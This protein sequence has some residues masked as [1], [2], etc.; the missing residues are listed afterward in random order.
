MIYISRESNVECQYVE[1]YA[2]KEAEKLLNNIAYRKRVEE[3]RKITDIEE[4]REKKKGFPYRMAHGYP[5]NPNY[6]RVGKNDDVADN[7]RLL[8]D[9]DHQDAEEISKMFESEGFDRLG[10]LRIERSIGGNG[11]HI[12][13][14]RMKGLTR[15]Q[16]I[17]FYEN[18]FQLHIDHSCKDVR[19][20][21]FLV[22]QSDVLYT[23]DEFYETVSA[24]IEN[25][26]PEDMNIDCAFYKY[27]I[28]NYIPYDYKCTYTND[29]AKELELLVDQ[30]YETGIDIT[31]TYESWY[32]IGFCIDTECGLSGLSLFLKISSLYTG[33]STKECTEK[34]YSL[35]NDNHHEI[36]IGSFIW[37]AREYGAM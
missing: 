25:I 23:T 19:R 15:E 20:K 22:P 12:D 10:V 3:L 33:Y 18:L 29:N 35:H 31:N 1:P 37:I 14:R 30:V 6:L 21:C 5:P 8:L 11:C 27:N 13:V 17:N 2:R 34:Y 24:P 26:V 32:R 28:D 9:F 7:G 16:N 4:Y 36:H